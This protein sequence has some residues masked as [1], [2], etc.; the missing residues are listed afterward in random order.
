[1]RSPYR[2]PL[3]RLEPNQPAKTFRIFTSAGSAAS[4]LRVR[5]NADKVCRD[6]AGKM[7]VH[8]WADGRVGVTYFGAVRHP[9]R[10][11]LAPERRI[12]PELWALEN[13]RTA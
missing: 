13:R 4:W 6:A 2:N 7:Q 8:K 11:R 3:T 5:A 12:T 9:Y 1:M 10:I